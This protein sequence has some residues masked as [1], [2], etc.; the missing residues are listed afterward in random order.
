M[1][2]LKQ[3]ITNVIASHQPRSC[4]SSLDIPLEDRLILDSVTHVLTEKQL[5]ALHKKGA[6][7]L[8][9][10]SMDVMYGASKR[11]SEIKINRY[12]PQ[13]TKG[14][15]PHAILVAGYI[16]SQLRTT[17]AKYYASVATSTVDL[18]KAMLPEQKKEIW[19]NYVRCL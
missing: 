1:Q 9:I 4:T 8:H 2:K 16:E 13:L 14:Y 5:K 11:F 18:Q 17:L 6:N 12:N 19:K 7:L 15:N 3:H 10:I